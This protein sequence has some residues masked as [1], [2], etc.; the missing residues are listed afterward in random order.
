LRRTLPVSWISHLSRCYTS[1]TR[2][3]IS[4]PERT[5]AFSG[6]LNREIKT[7]LADQAIGAKPCG[8]TQ[9]LN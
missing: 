6:K 8:G 4:D 3:V 9:A 5:A 2:L 1:R 7:A